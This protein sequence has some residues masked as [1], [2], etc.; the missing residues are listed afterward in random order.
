MVVPMVIWNAVSMLSLPHKIKER[1]F[2][3]ETTKFVMNKKVFPFSTLQKK[4]TVRS[5]DQAVAFRPVPNSVAS[6]FFLTQV[7]IWYFPFLPYSMRNRVYTI[8]Y[9][10][11]FFKYKAIQRSNLMYFSFSDSLNSG[12][13][14][15]S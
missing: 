10:W 9:F 4:T 12:I 5:F 1:I 2:K 11:W 14:L 6:F 13:I 15:A 3:L 8:S 7:N